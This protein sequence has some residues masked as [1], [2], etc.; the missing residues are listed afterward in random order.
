MSNAWRF[1]FLCSLLVAEVVRAADPTEKAATTPAPALEAVVTTDTGEFVIRLLPEIAPRHAAH[2]AR[3]ARAGGYDRTAFHRIIPRGI[4]QGGDPN[5][6]DPR[7]AALF[8]KGGLGLLKAEFSDRPFTRGAVG[9]ARRPSSVDSGGSQFF[10]CLSDQPSLKGQYTLFGEVV[11]G[12]DVVDR[13]GATP[14]VGDRPTERIE[15]RRVVIR[16]VDPAA[17]QTGGK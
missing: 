5:T 8:G 14:V 17:A 7:K 15:V 16:E 2:F 10:I 9:A 4:V 12:L 1:A 3:T 11:A 13:I 6:R